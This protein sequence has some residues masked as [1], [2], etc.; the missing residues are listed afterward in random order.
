M[1]NELP[2]SL[3][4]IRTP[5]G[6]GPLRVVAG[7]SPVPFTAIAKQY[8]HAQHLLNAY[9]SF[10]RPAGLQFLAFWHSNLVFKPYF[11]CLSLA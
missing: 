8:A 4:V 10:V 2:A 5:D 9:F 7:A 3:L 1:E 6:V 11:T